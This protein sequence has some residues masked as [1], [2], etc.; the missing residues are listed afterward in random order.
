MEHYGGRTVKYIQKIIQSNLLAYIFIFILISV[1]V[2]DTAMIAVCITGYAVTRNAGN[3]GNITAYALI[4][5]F[6]FTLSV[7]LIK[8]IK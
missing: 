6:A 2:I 4:I 7:Y 3:L 5:S 8:K 1:L